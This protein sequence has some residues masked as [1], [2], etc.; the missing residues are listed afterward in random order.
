MDVTEDKRVSDMGPLGL[1]G[2]YRRAN[3][4]PE[5][6]DAWRTWLSELVAARSGA[7]V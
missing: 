7:A 3:M 4:D 6:I 1:G 5:G 2:I